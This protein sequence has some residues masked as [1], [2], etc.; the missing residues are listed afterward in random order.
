MY[1]RR[2]NPAFTTQFRFCVDFDSYVLDYS[3][4]MFST[5]IFIYS[6]S[7]SKYSTSNSKY[8]TSTKI[9]LFVFLSATE[10]HKFLYPYKTGTLSGI[11]NFTIL[12]NTRVINLWYPACIFPG[13]FFK[14]CGNGNEQS[15]TP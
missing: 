3:I 2:I 4:Y 1:L 11:K 6:T 9:L 7:N 8:S 10:R 14:M 12:L 13:I 5:S 15:S